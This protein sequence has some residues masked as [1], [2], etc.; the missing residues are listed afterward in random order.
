[1]TRSPRDGGTKRQKNSHEEDDSKETGEERKGIIKLSGS[2]HMS[3]VTAEYLKISG[4]GDVSGKVSVDNMSVSGSCSVGG[5]IFVS[6]NLEAS[7]SLRAKKL[8]EVET[9]EISGSLRAGSIRA[10]SLDSSGSLKVEGNIAA[11]EMDTSGSC[12][13]VNIT[14]DTLESSGSL[15]VENISGKDIKIYG[16]IRAE[17]VDCEMFTMLVDGGSHR[18][19]IGKLNAGE[20]KISPRRKF[21]KSTIEIGEITCREGSLE[22]VRARKVVAD[23]VVIGDGC[24]IDYVEA[25]VI[26]TSGDA[27]IKE[28]KVLL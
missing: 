2:M 19:S 3:E 5:D 27:V 15:E 1:L 18:K 11:R 7:G 16:A 26:K 25:K 22:S 9:I 6:H 17:T 24:V 21:F 14:S 8:I 13:A 10:G 23:K 12:H 20:V 4:S 28:K